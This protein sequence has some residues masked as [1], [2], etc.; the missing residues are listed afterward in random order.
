VLCFGAR[1]GEGVPII[2]VDEAHERG[3]GAGA[4][5]PC[6]ELQGDQ[7]V[8]VLDVIVH[9]DETATPAGW[10]VAPELEIGPDQRLQ[11]VQAA[12]PSVTTRNSLGCP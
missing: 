9:R 10:V 11:M 6:L 1:A 8:M 3:M 7:L 5:R 2:A 4:R 12:T